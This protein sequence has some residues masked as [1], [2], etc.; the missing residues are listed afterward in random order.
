[1]C[2]NCANP[3]AT[4]CSAV[5]TGKDT[6]CGTVSGVQYYLNG[7]NCVSSC[8]STY[9]NQLVSGAYVCFSC[10]LA[11]VATCSGPSTGMATSCS[12]SGSTQM[13]LNTSGNCVAFASCPSASGTVSGTT[14]LGV[15]TPCTSTGALTCSGVGAGKDLTCGDIAG[16]QSY[17]TST[18]TCV[19][20]AN[21]PAGPGTLSPAKCST[22]TGTAVLTCLNGVATSCETSCVT[23]CSSGQFPNSSNVCAAPVTAPSSALIG[24]VD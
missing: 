8:P 18:A 3:A 16:V 11:G 12:K 24:Y 13:Y 23:S 22:C 7:G 20:A 4:A 9:F 2:N 5:G 1:M 17:L 15:C 19:T 21:C 6:V 14:S 10:V